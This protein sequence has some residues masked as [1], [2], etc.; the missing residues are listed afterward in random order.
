VP[1]PSSARAEPDLSAWV[2]LV[3]V[4]RR[5]R[6]ECAWK[7]AQTHRSL[8]RHLLEEAHEL[9]E[10]LDGLEPGLASYD[11]PTER[12]HLR[13][14]LGDVLLQVLF[15]AS[16][17]EEQGW[18][19]VEDVAASLRAK[20]VRRNPHVFGEPTAE[21][22]GETDPERINALWE[23][24]KAQEKQRDDLLEGIAVTLP[25]LSRATKVLDRRERGGLSLPAPAPDQGAEVGEEL[26]AL[27]ERARRDGLDPEQELRE[28]VRRL[29]R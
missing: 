9:A 17:A 27:V 4:M 19:D 2:E 5:L 16:I 29:G 11:D 1:H 22:F 23:S 28:A 10:V 14:E 12:E 7:G 6:H 18:F 8:A 3:A 24:A 25:A 15:H 13:E 20:L 21:G 26:L